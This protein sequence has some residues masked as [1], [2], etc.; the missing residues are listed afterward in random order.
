MQEQTKR[1]GKVYL[2]GAGPGDPRLITLRAVQCL[3]RADVVLYDYLVNPAILEHAPPGAELVCLGSHRSGRII[4]QDEINAAMVAAAK[5]GRTVVRL[6]G[7][8]PD[9][10]AR[11]AEEMEA[12]ERVGIDF[13]TVPGVTA[14]LAAA[15]YAGIPITHSQYA[16][17]LAL[18]TGH[19]RQ[20]KEQSSL[21]YAALARFPGTLIFYMG[22]TSAGQWSEM[23]IRHGRSPDTPTMIVRRCTWN[24]QETIR[25]TLGTVG[26]KIAE[27][28]IRPPAI[29][30]VGEVVALAPRSSWFA[31]KPLFGKRILV[32]RPRVQARAL[33]DRLEELGALTLIQPAIR[34]GPPTDWGKIDAALERLDQYDW[35]VFSSSN[36]VEYLLDRLEQKHGDLRRLGKV[37]LAAIGPGTAEELARYRLRADVVPDQ[38]RAEA[39]ADVLAAEPTAARFLLARAS[40]GREVLAEKLAAA[41]HA[42]DQIVVYSS[43]DVEQAEA[44]ILE[45]LEAGRIDWVTAS[46][47]SIARSL[48]RLFR[49]RLRRVKLASISPIT[50]AILRE[51]GYPPA[52]EAVRYTMEGLAE[53]IESY[54]EK[55]AGGQRPSDLLAQRAPANVAQGPGAD[56]KAHVHG[57]TLAA[58]GDLQRQ[59]QPEEQQEQRRDGDP[60][61]TEG[62]R[63]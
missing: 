39:L 52:A 26:R 12:L 58:E 38:Y 60:E 50:S 37:R 48:V 56:D 11:S 21:N 8:D 57:D 2:V 33:V 7:G 46:S 24:D 36:G 4:S 54:E 1:T 51:L 3:R 25:C 32:T 45:A 13:E 62:F 6:K 42:V 31:A 44:E 40:R 43:S 27:Q 17:A 23:L 53:A 30:V 63:H 14:A 35:L 16:S 34:I 18:V 22:I 15:G 9:I 19:E 55:A 5:T 47:S 61:E 41:G 28:G 10:F 29:I 49:E 20:D 59:V